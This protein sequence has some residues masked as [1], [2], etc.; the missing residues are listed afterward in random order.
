MDYDSRDYCLSVMLYSLI[1]YPKK[2][3]ILTETQ[4]RGG[5]LKPMVEVV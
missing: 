3:L 4:Q 2:H 5:D 1:H